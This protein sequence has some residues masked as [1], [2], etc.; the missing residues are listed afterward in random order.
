MLILIQE[1]PL[2]EQHNF[3]FGNNSTFDN[4]SNPSSKWNDNS[5]SGISITNISVAGD[6][7]TITV[8][9]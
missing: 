6:D 8:S 5:S 3:F 9:K 2:D 1:I 4:N 7:M